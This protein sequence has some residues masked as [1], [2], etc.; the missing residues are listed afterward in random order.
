M[1]ITEKVVLQG[2]K[3]SMQGVLSVQKEDSWEKFGERMRTTIN[4]NIIILNSLLS[5]DIAEDEDKGI[6][7]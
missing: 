5:L 2:V 7:L 1:T 3:D 4:Q 6:Q